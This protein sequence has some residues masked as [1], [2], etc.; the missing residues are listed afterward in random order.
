MSTNVIEMEREAL[1]R[2]A[3]SRPMTIAEYVMARMDLGVRNM[4]EVYPPPAQVV[5][6]TRLRYAQQVC[7]LFRR[8]Y[9]FMNLPCA[10]IEES[11]L[12]RLP[13]EKH[14]T[15]LDWVAREFYYACSGDTLMVNYDNGGS[16][17]TYSLVKGRTEETA[18]MEKADADAEEERW[19]QEGQGWESNETEMAGRSD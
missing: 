4:I 9:D 8:Y 14:F 2:Q 19:R 10:R 13:G 11:K 7:K 18:R 3:V 1:R 17:P 6:I 16:Y 12:T 5:A 15:K